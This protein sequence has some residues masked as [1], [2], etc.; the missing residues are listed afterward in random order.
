MTVITEPFPLVPGQTADANQLEA[1]L[2][3]VRSVVNGQL[4]MG[5]NVQAGAASAIDGDA[6]S[7][8]SS[9]LGAR[10]DHVHAVR[11]VEVLSADPSAK[12]GRLYY[13]NVSNTLRMCILASPATWVTIGN[14]SGTDLPAHASRHAS[15]GAD[16]MPNNSIAE[17]MLK[18]RTIFAGV[19]AA[20]VNPS[21]N[22]WTD[23]VTG[24]APTIT[25]S[26]VAWLVINAGVSNTSGSNSP[27]YAFRVIDGAG[28]CLYMSNNRQMSAA[29]ANNDASPFSAVYPVLLAATPT[30]K[31]QVNTDL[32][33]PRVLKSQTINAQVFAVTA[34]QVV[35]G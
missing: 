24:V 4:E 23:V 21:A 32:T 34:L 16:P 19:P 1:D 2:S 8:G 9:A 7:P 31:L 29:G 28:A 5:V 25:V 17:T 33:G 13:N 22:A 10:A 3:L 27:K 30:L 18:A 35:V 14:M 15:G 20:D 12:V 6:S 26:Q 11:G